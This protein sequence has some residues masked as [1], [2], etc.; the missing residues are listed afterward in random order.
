MFEIVLINMPFADVRIP[1]LAL[2][3]IKYVV[4]KAF[5]GRVH[6]RILYLNHEF[7][8]YLGAQFCQ[9]VGLGMK[10]HTSGF[11]DWF[12][13]KTAFPEVPD[14]IADY[15]LRYHPRKDPET[16]RFKEFITQKRRGLDEFIDQLISRYDIANAQL[17]GFTS[18]FSQNVASFALARKLKQLR[19]EL[20]IVIGGA[21]C[22]TPMGEEIARHVESIDYVFSGPALVNFPAFIESRLNG[23]EPSPHIA[24]IFSKQNTRRV[25]DY[26]SANTVRIGEAPRPRPLGDELDINIRIP[27]DYDQFLESYERHFPELPG[28][29]SLTFETSRGCWWGEKAHCTFCGLNGLTMSYRAMAPPLALEQFRSLFA[30]SARCSTLQCVDNILPKSYFKEVLQK[31][32]TPSNMS[33]FYE[34]KADLSEED[35]RTLAKARV[36]VIQPGIEALASSTLK[37]MKKGVSSFQNVAL[38]KNCAL[39]NVKPSWNLLV[40]FPGEKEEVFQKYVRDIPLL[41]HLPPPSGVFPVRFD[42]YSPYFTKADTYGLK[43]RPYEYYSM[44]YPFPEQSLENLAYYFMDQNFEAGY[45]L[46][47]LNWLAPMQNAVETWK[48]LWHDGDP[49]RRPRLELRTDAGETVVFDS[50]AGTPKQYRIESDG[51]KLLQRLNLP[52]TV[53]RLAAEFV[54]TTGAEFS[55]T[56]T[57]LRQR[58]LVFEE[59]DRFLNLMLRGAGESEILETSNSVEDR[60]DPVLVGC[61]TASLVCIAGQS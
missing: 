60:E 22:E 25:L 54:S 39:H 56:L 2:T 18:M 8:P 40:G 31:L 36:N 28:G 6:A 17:V 37:L 44:T 48:M 38:L 11:G 61:S 42:R 47:M 58:G 55:Q 34:V 7:A 19:N 45:F 4:E 43:L 46:A 57:T 51:L 20:T 21:N 29:P 14:N 33:I 50:R 53:D 49:E 16:L 24:G 35:V 23:E 30:Y 9:E 26:P 12:F 27:L 1:S 3:Q 10:H 15:L 13:R 59:N 52:T 32:E 5:P 41:T